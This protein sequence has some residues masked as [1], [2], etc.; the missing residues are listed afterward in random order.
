MSTSIQEHSYERKA[1]VTVGIT[2]IIMALAAFFS[3][4]YIHGKLVVPG[5]ASTTF[6]YITASYGLFK[7]EILGWIIILISD[8][9]VSWALYIFLKPVHKNLSLL[10]ACLRLIYSS[11]LGI[12]ILNLLMVMLLSGHSKP[13]L[14]M[15]QTQALMILCLEAFE[16]FW[17]VGLVVFGSHLLIVGYVALKSN[18]IPKAISILV[19]LAGI[20][21]IIIHL[22][23]TF[24]SQ[25]DALIT[26]L[27]V[28]FAIPMVAGELGL[29]IWM[30]IKGGKPSHRS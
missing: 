1:A 23:K 25:Y 3:Y 28:V 11:L 15:E 22:S 24:L 9:V 14:P 5:D 2:L 4:S 12:A 13:S 8:V 19:L 10:G 6:N 7:A 21:Y 30:L 20:G 18:C 17:S 16:Q 27:Q 26:V 29:G